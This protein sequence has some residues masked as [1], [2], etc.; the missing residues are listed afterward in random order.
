ML[1]ALTTTT[2][3]PHSWDHVPRKRSGRP[4]T[5]WL[6][7][8]FNFWRFLCSL[9]LAPAQVYEQKPKGFYRGEVPSHPVWRENLFI[10][11]TGG[12]PLLVQI[13][14]YLLFPGERPPSTVSRIRASSD[15]DPTSYP[16]EHKWHW[17]PSFM[18]YHLVFVYFL[19]SL[20]RRMQ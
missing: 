18:F 19:V 5:E 4:P 6:D 9:D 16:T 13:F 12:F 20:V 8:P 17:F 2:D 7:Q 10:L 3:L 14:S 11:A 15:A 1:R